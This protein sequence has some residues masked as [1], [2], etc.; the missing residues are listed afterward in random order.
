M[1]EALLKKEDVSE[2]PVLAQHSAWMQE[3]VDENPDINED[4]VLSV[5]ENGI[6]RVFLNVL[7]DA[8]VFKR[9]DAGKQAFMRFVDFIG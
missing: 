3:L 9:D 5:I 8:G 6:G 2:H 1:R 7:E 4:N